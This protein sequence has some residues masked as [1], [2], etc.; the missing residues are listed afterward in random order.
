MHHLCHITDQVLAHVFLGSEY[1]PFFA[2][3]IEY[4][5]AV[6]GGAEFE[7]YGGVVGVDQCSAKIGLWFYWI[8]FAGTFL[9]F[10]FVW[11]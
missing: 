2:D 6:A 8:E 4:G 10:K 11:K 9:L 7:L 1:H 5:G 3:R